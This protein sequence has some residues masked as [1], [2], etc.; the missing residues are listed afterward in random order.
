MIDL[1]R[2]KQEDEN[3]LHNLLQFYIYEFTVFQEIKLEEN[4]SYA[5]FDLK[6]YWTE[7]DMHAFFIMYNGEYAGFAMVETGDPN[8][9]LE[10][11]IM[12]KFY[13]RGFGKIAAC[14]LFNKF[15]GKWSITQ[16]AK[17]EPARSFWR[18][19][20]GDYTGGSYIETV[21]DF[22]RSIQEFDTALIT[23]N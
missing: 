15:P 4:G 8:V 1:V 12:R 16:V 19:V 10:F 23:K 17:N 6:P 2:V 3:I 5:P 20:I 14:E 11:F 7:S 9:I 18:M 21:D 22:N 13:R